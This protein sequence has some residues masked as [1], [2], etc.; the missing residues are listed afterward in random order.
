METPNQ[1]KAQKTR[2]WSNGRGSGGDSIFG[3]FSHFHSASL[4]D[5]S[6][7]PGAD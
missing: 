5:E 2:R 1:K 3:H 7:T 6:K 4:G